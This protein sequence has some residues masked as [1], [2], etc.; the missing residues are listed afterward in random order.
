V[1]RVKAL[2]AALCAALTMTVFAAAALADGTSV[3]EGQSDA[4]SLWHIDVSVNFSATGS[5]PDAANLGAGT[6]RVTLPGVD[7]NYPPSFASTGAEPAGYR[8]RIVDG[9]YGAPATGFECSTDGT[10]NGAGLRF[11][12][13]MTLHLVAAACYTFPPDGS[14]QPAVADVWASPSQTGGAPDGSFPLSFSAPCTAA[15]TTDE[16]PIV[17][18]KAAKCVVPN[19]KNL[20]LLRATSKLAK[21]KCRLGRVKRVFSAKVKAG[22][23]VSQS[24]KPGKKMPKGS[25]VNLVLSKG[26]PG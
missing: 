17:Q 25:R 21:A 1:T 13:D 15:P 6:V 2:L 7:P 10:A 16:T 8:C 23:V 22:R 11:P 4:D 24:R 9:A 12:T 20:T 5:G 14:P 3:A 18:P 19:L 26:P